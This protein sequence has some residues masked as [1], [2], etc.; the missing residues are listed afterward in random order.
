MSVDV[1]IIRYMEQIKLN[2]TK[3]SGEVSPNCPQVHN[4]ITLRKDTL[5]H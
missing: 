5:I 3:E 2:C 1:H 4:A